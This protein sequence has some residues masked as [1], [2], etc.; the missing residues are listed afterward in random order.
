MKFTVIGGGAV[1]LLLASYL[2]QQGDVTIVVRRKEQ[3]ETLQNG[4]TRICGD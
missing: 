2:A 3:Q 4:L 1:G